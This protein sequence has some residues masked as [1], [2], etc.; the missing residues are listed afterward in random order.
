MAGK[1][2]QTMASVKMI[3]PLPSVT[4]HLTLLFLMTQHVSNNRTPT[5][6][7]AGSAYALKISLRRHACIPSHFPACVS[8][9]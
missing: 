2:T 1:G 8:A 9:A 4:L 3:T 6:P 5:L 7:S